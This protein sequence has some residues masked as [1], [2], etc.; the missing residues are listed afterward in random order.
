MTDVIRK[1][2]LKSDMLYDISDFYRGGDVVFYDFINKSKVIG[3]IKNGVLTIKK[4]F[5]WDGCTPK[6]RLFGVIFG[7]PDFKETYDASLIHDFLIK[8]SPFHKMSRKTMDDI[9]E[10]FLRLNNFKYTWL[11][12]NAVHLYRKSKSHTSSYF[13]NII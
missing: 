12:A 13:F 11:Y 3:F 4:G 2:Y 5:V 10:Y 7:V 8:T 6:F 1:Y 9:F